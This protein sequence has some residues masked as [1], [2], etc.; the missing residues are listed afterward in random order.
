MSDTPSLFIDRTLPPE[1]RVVQAALSY[2]KAYS[3]IPTQDQIVQALSQP[4]GKS[5]GKATVNKYWGSFQHQLAHELSLTGWLP[6]EIPG[7]VSEHLIA[8]VDWARQSADEELIARQS[9]LDDREN[10]LNRTTETYQQRIE[11]LTE[12]NATYSVK[13]EQQANVIESLNQSVTS[14]N[15]SLADT[16]K[17]HAVTAEKHAHADQALSRVSDELSA[18]ALHGSEQQM[19]IDQLRLDLH[20][21]TSQHHSLQRQHDKLSVTQTWPM[22]M[23]ILINAFR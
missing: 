21:L 4:D 16:E 10:T 22:S 9:Q 15:K 8:L 13:L 7:F 17:A 1:E 18:S 12:T 2:L 23:R 5:T 3:R 11:T 14:L 19:I 20:Q 6:S